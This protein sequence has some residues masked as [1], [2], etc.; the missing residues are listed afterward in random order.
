MIELINILGVTYQIKFLDDLIERENLYGEIDYTN[1]IIRI[2]KNMKKDRKSRT[3][4][5]EIMHGIMESLG[6]SEINCDEEKVQ[7]ISNALY[8]VLEN[9]PK[10]LSLFLGLS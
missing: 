7:N 10:L 9:N 4:I 5:H 3:L 2:D 6:Y 8:L 1:Q